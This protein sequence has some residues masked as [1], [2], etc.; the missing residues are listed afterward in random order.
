MSPDL[1]SRLREKETERSA[2]LE[3]ACLLLEAD[4]R[5]VAAWLAGSLGRG[6]GDAWSDLDLWVAVR[7]ADMEAVRVGRRDFVAALGEPVLISEAPQN[8][9]PGGAYLWT[10]YP[11]SHGPMHV[12]WNWLPQKGAALPHDVHILFDKVG[13]PP[14]QEPLQEPPTG[15]ELAASLT[16]ECAFFWGMSSV[17]A[18]YI[19]RGDLYDALNL[20]NIAASALGKVRWLLG[21]GHKMTYRDNAWGSALAPFEPQAQLDLLRR[22]QDEMEVLHSQLEAQGGKAPGR[23]LREVHALMNL[24]Q[25]SLDDQ[26]EG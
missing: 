6:E 13:L 26:K 19:A 8:A 9:P 18:K 12:D 11:G 21:K 5:I 16:Q 4:R 24:V 23:A 10:L 2:L 15:Q 20:L 22:M 1:A 25:M 14:A 7:D 3:Q 17:V